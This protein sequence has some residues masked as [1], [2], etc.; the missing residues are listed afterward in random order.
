MSNLQVFPNP[1]N[2]IITINS[3]ETM[4]IVY[5]YDSLGHIILTKTNCSNNIT[6]D[7]REYKGLVLLYIVFKDGNKTIAKEVLR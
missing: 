7:L 2:G 4:E 3:E 6:L 5:V 1:S